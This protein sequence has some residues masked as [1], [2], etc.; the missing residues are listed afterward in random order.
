VDAAANGERRVNRA[1]WHED[2]Y[3]GVVERVVAD[4]DPF[5]RCDEAVRE[6]DA[7]RRRAC[8]AECPAMQGAF[9]KKMWGFGESE[10][11]VPL[12]I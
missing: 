12:L 1:N 8:P 9:S 3:S 11:S 10:R 7:F 2:L 5:A 4:G 6:C